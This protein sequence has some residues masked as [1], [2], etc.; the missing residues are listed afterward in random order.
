MVDL[1]VFAILI[2]VMQG[3][4]GYPLTAIMLKKEGRRVLEKYRHGQWAETLSVDEL[5]M[6]R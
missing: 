5:K 1:S 6:L 3:F 2:Y 4:A